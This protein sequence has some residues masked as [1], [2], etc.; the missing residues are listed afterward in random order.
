MLKLFLVISLLYSFSAKAE[1]FILN[2]ANL[3]EAA[4]K[5][6]PELERIKSQLSKSR[7]DR[8]Q[9]LENFQTKIFAN[10]SYLKTNENA[11][12]S[13]APN[14]SPQNNYSIGVSKN[15]LS[16][17]DLEISNVLA[18]NKYEGIG[19][20]SRNY[21]STRITIDLYQNI[22]GR[23]AKAELQDFFYQQKMQELQQRIDNEIFYITLERLY[24]SIILNEE[25]I[26]TSKELLKLAEKQKKDIKKRLKN[27]VSDQAEYSRQ[28]S[29]VFSQ[30]TEISS[31]E[32]KRSNYLRDLKTLLPD[33]SAKIVIVEDYN[34]KIAEQYFRNIVNLIREIPSAPLSYT[35]YDDVNEILAKSYKQKQKATKRYSDADI[36]FYTEARQ[37]GRAN[38]NEDSYQDLED[39][40]ENSIE[41]GVNLSFPIDGRRSKSKRLKQEM[42]K[43]DFLA[44]QNQTI[45][46]INAYHSQ[47]L[48]N[49]AYLDSLLKYQKENS[50]SLQKVVK[51]NRKKYNQARISINDLISDQNLYLKSKI[52][53]INVKLSIINQI[54]DYLS[55]F[56]TTP[57]AIEND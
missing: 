46:K 37:I 15:F 23:K 19:V 49:I 21:L 9:F 42:E 30:I 8:S 20:D 16:G 29:Q 39:T 48:Q 14:V 7:L 34:F 5:N 54:L 33:I 17:V 1:N 43:A 10:A 31:L 3:I 28:E 24:W 45:A 25:A 56:T 18:R 55:V 52:N 50:N 6:S 11:F 47:F 27:G 22:F 35:L 36:E 4:K 41:V 26:K 13:F 2:K 53:E 38:K 40:P 44:Q 32:S 51:V 57:F 12:V